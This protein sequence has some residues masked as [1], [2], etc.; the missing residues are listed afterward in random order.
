MDTIIVAAHNK[1]STIDFDSHLTQMLFTSGCNFRCSY[2]HNCALWEKREKTLTL[3]QLDQLLENAK[4]NW[5]DA[6]CITGGEP[7]IH[8]DLPELISFIKHKG[9]SVKLDTNGSNP[10][11]LAR[12]INQVDYFALD[13]KISLEKYPTIINVNFDNDKEWQ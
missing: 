10:D 4:D 8:P 2:C 13:Y 6:V 3:A 5:V 11:M 12:L 1:E 9:L 7:T